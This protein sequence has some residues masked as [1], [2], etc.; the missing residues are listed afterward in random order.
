MTFPVVAFIVQTAVYYGI[1]NVFVY[2]I[3]V[4]GTLLIAHAA[5]RHKQ[6]LCLP[7]QTHQAEACTPLLPG[8]CVQGEPMPQPPPESH[9]S[10]PSLWGVGGGGAEGILL[11]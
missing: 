1:C 10:S 6:L 4:S 9:I 5:P 2:L 8:P 3:C 7:L 11:T